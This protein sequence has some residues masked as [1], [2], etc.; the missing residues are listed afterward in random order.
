MKIDQ[1]AKNLVTIQ[2]GNATL[3]VHEDANEL[4]ES[5][6]HLDFGNG[7]RLIIENLLEESPGI[8]VYGLAKDIIIL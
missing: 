3:T 1:T 6:I 4:D 8:Y 2:L 5:E 7:K